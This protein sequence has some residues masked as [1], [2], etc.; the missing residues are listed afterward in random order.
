MRR[1]WATL[2]TSCLDRITAEDVEQ[3]KAVRSLARGQR[4]NRRIM[5]ATVNRE[6]ACLKA[7]FNHAIKSDLPV[8][9]PVSRV[10]FLAEH[11]E[12]TRVLSFDEHCGI[13]RGAA[14][15][16]LRDVATLMLETKIGPE[17]A[18]AFSRRT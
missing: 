6:L 5:P 14:T 1:S 17:E 13:W 10:G 12:Q 18:C 3:V 16:L 4:T 8:R 15:P 9:N 11:N 7:L 2:E